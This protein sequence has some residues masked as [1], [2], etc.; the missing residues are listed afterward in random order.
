VIFIDTG[1]FIARYLER[2]QYHDAAVARWLVLQNDG[3][4]CFTTNYVLDETITLLAR[5][6]TYAFACERARNLYQSTALTILR[7]V[8][9]DEL[10]ALELCAKYADQS[11]SFTDCI[12]F[13]MMDKHGITT[14]FSFDRHFTVAGYDIEP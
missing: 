1:A 2:D 5:R 12:S 13:V 9:T 7:P 4:S 10:L 8:V 11:V 6:S 14:A 3:R